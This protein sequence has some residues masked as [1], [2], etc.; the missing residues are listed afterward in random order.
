MTVELIE[1]RP[2][3]DS[4]TGVN[5]LTQWPLGS[6]TVEFLAATTSADSINRLRKVDFL[7]SYISDK[8]LL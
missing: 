4:V 8:C 2:I 1:K 7:S 3:Y 6:D 5:N